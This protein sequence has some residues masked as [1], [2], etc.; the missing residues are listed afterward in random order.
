MSKVMGTVE[1]RRDMA[2]AIEAVRIA[3]MKTGEVATTTRQ[4]NHL[5]TERFN[6]RVI[7]VPQ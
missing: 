1:G 4:A 3:A 7:N 5:Q 2:A 6:G